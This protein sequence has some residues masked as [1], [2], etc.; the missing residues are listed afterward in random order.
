MSFSGFSASRNS[1]WAMMMFET[2]SSTGWPRKMTLSLRSREKM[3]YVRSPRLVCSTTQGIVIIQYSL[4]AVASISRND[5]EFR[6][7]H[8]ERSEGPGGAGGAQTLPPRSLATLG[9]TKGG[10][11]TGRAVPPRRVHDD[12]HH[13][14]VHQ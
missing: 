4:L 11:S 3:S 7:C 5:F 10:L 12:R 14:L 6:S 2:V 13:L 9:M 8:P 1:N